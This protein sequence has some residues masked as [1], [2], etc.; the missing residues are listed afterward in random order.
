[1]A[2]KTHR[3]SPYPKTVYS[4]IGE[5]GLQSARVIAPMLVE[6]F[7]IRSV[8]DF[9]C[10]TGSWL[11]AFREVGVEDVLG[12]DFH[13]L[14]GGA[15]LIPR[16]KFRTVDLRK[17]V[18]LDR[19][20]DLVVCVEVVEHLPATAADALIDS[21]VNAGDIILFSGAIPGQLGY[22]HVNE[23]WQSHW[24]REFSRRGM[25]AVDWIRPKIW[26]HPRVDFWYAQNSLLFLSQS[27]LLG[28]PRLMESVGVAHES[29]SVVHPLLY[30]DRSAVQKS[31]LHRAAQW[32]VQKFPFLWAWLSRRRA[33]R[34]S[35][36][37]TEIWDEH[38]G[39][40]RVEQH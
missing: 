20:F 25:V 16:E 7:R 1:M 18:T 33:V 22:A 39:E 40:E 2:R 32:S 9:G 12:L 37:A 38:T 30:L 34:L 3:D 31:R 8:V 35:K 29:L 15:L 19:K 11:A 4:L 26:A 5:G 28:F 36:L 6:H 27:A 14:D 17:P 10:G 13:R 23:Q 21:L 24:V